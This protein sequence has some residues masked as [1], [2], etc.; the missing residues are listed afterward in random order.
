MSDADWER[1]I[2][3]AARKN[4][5]NVRFIG[6][7]PTLHP[8]L[9]RLIGQALGEGMQAEVYTN[10][11]RISDRLW[12]VL[13]QPGVSVATSWYSDD[14]GEHD[15]IT[16]RPAYHRTLANIKSAVE[17][18]IPVRAGLVRLSSGQ[19]TGPAI[20]QLRQLGVRRASVDDV[21]QVGRGVRDRQPGVRELCGACTG[22]LA[23]FSDGGVHPCVFAR[24]LLVG[25]VR[26]QALGE[27]LDGPA[28]AAARR[29][30]TE[31]LSLRRQG[32]C[33]PAAC[34]PNDGDALCIPDHC[35]PCCD[36]ENSG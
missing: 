5:R 10:L 14:P 6:G 1:V 2:E 27:I 15:R 21:R 22:T 30:I 18:G 34:P 25:D 17:R 13:S 4:V 26:T 33:I 12:E 20:E 36:P 8:A 35:S 32:D 16:G 28:L 11:V 24:W 9:P 19:R 7:E 23:V 29:T 3:Q 31:E